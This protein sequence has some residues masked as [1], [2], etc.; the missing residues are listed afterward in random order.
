M[1]VD[2]TLGDPVRDECESCARLA[3]QL[4]DGWRNRARAAAR[5]D[6]ATRDAAQWSMEACLLL[7]ATIRARHP[8]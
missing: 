8:R 3:E 2:S 4:A 7:A 5:D 1:T 6:H